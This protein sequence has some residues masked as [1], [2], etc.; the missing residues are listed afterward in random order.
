MDASRPL[1]HAALLWAAIALA[2]TVLFWPSL[3]H[4]FYQDDFTW[5][6]HSQQA[7]TSPSH[8]FDSWV[9][10]FKR[11]LGQSWFF[12]QYRIFGLHPILFNL[13]SVALHAATAIALVSLASVRGIPL[14]TGLA[15]SFLFTLGLGHA[16][17]PVLWACSQP[18][19]LGTLLL[20]G[21]LLVLYRGGGAVSGLLALFLML[22]SVSSHD[23][24]LLAPFG[25]ALVAVTAGR[26]R[27]LAALLASVGVAMLLVTVRARVSMVQDVSPGATV[28]TNVLQYLAS[29]G[30]PLTS[31]RIPMD[32][33]ESAG[34]PVV[35]TAVPWIVWG[36]GSVV[37]GFLV[38]VARRERRWAEC[39]LGALLILPAALPTSG[40]PHWVE[41]RYAYP[42]VAVWSLLLLH[43]VLQI[44]PRL[45]R[46]SILLLLGVGS[47][48][49]CAYMQQQAVADGEIARSS[50]RWEQIQ[51][52][53]A[54]LDGPAL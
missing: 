25:V 40:G 35:A 18:I 53:E 52:R 22:L 31:L 30:A 5:L 27:T 45:A 34:F 44:R 14:R 50:P 29:L 46:G 13:V 4:G 39:L 41:A 3:R 17:K 8:L 10:E 16:G 54:E 19:L 28:V 26:S 49:G 48:I 43:G 7:R 1:K 32:L 20:L 47:L 2:S 21:C 36:L 9:S 33:L 38:R 6:L 15:A 23:V 51:E 42:A 24:F 37:A 12:L 11:P